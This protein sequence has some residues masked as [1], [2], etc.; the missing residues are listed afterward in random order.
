MTHRGDVVI[1][2]FPFVGGGKGKTRPA[3]VVQCDRLNRL[4]NN[5]V[6]VMVTS[7]RRLIGR[8]PSHFLIDPATSDGASSGL[9][10]PSAVKCEHCVTLVQEDIL[11]TIGH[12]SDPLIH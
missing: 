12:L 8:E 10:F 2:D 7:N 11:R 4:L 6:V 9:S 1:V 3:V 5:T